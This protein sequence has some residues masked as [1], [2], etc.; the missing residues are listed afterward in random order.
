MRPSAFYIMLSLVIAIIA[1]ANMNPIMPE[2]FVGSDTYPILFTSRY[3]SIAEMWQMIGSRLM[4]GL[5]PIDFYRPV[6]GIIWGACYRLWGLDAWGYLRLNQLLHMANALLLVPVAIALFGKAG[7]M[8]GFAG[9]ALFALYPLSVDNVPV[10]PRMPDLLVGTLIMLTLLLHSAK[11]P[12][13]LLCRVAAPVICLAAF[14][15]KETAFLLPALLFFFDLCRGRQWKASALRA[16]PY[17]ILLALYLTVRHSVLGG[18]GGYESEGSPFLRAGGTL[19]S[20]VRTLFLPFDP[21]EASRYSG[22]APFLGRLGA[23]LLV[24][25]LW[26]R[27]DPMIPVRRETHRAALFLVI[28]IAAVVLLHLPVRRFERRYIYLASLPSSLFLV[29]LM[30][31][32]PRGRLGRIAASTAAFLIVWQVSFAPGFGGYQEWKVGDR[33]AREYLAHAEPLILDASPDKPVTLPD[34]PWKVISK[35][36]RVPYVAQAF[37]LSERSVKGYMALR[38]PDY[39]GEITVGH[40]K[41]YMDAHGNTTY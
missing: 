11:G 13:R 24:A 8:P 23:G 32:G 33:L 15:V 40:Q 25:L 16:L 35:P 30:L 20:Y 34:T 9:A 6:A 5:F 1:V 2:G 22:M 38:H 31:A 12:P 19:V 36:K 14:G 18:I 10:V 17:A 28:W 29:W 4:P 21:I 26:H 41:V 3:S 7:R 37:I 39:R 27:N